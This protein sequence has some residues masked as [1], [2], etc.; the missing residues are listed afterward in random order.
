MALTITEDRVI[1][2]GPMFSKGKAESHFHLRRILT[3]LEFDIPHSYGLYSDSPAKPFDHLFFLYMT[4]YSSRPTA[5]GTFM[6]LR[7]TGLGF[8]P[9]R[10]RE[11]VTAECSG[12]PKTPR[13]SR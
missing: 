6:A 11:G 10:L 3:I 8:F 9:A 12:S 5:P 2:K 4:S 7:L 13:G 1:R